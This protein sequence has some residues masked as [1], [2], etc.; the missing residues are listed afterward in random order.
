MSIHVA[1]IQVV[2]S[3]GTSGNNVIAARRSAQQ[4]LKLCWK[5]HRGVLAQV[6]RTVDVAIT[7]LRS[8]A[9]ETRR[10]AV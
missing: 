8:D 10:L 6:W 7:N 3:A 9:A 4:R 1:P 2:Q 5:L